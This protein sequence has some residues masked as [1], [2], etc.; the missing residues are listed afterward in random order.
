[1]DV[2]NRDDIACVC[3]GEEDCKVST[4]GEL[5]ETVWLRALCT[6]EEHIGERED[7]VLYDILTRLCVPGPITFSLFIPIKII[8]R[9][10]FHIYASLYNV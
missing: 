7:E 4:G 1:M 10:E 3:V 2:E 8:K 6:I 9:C 5:R